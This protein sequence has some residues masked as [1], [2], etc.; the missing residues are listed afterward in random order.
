MTSRDLVRATLAFSRGDT[1]R[2]ARRASISAIAA[3]YF[4]LLSVPAV[5]T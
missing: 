4:M 2:K 1:Q 3:R 5:S